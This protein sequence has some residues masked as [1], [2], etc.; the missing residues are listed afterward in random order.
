MT[1]M[2]ISAVI[3][4]PSLRLSRPLASGASLH[5]ADI[6]GAVVITADEKT[7]RMLKDHPTS[8]SAPFGGQTFRGWT[9]GV[10]AMNRISQAGY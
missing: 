7:M 3:C 10:Q 5:I 8:I 4:S 6:D 2:R 9:N 1:K